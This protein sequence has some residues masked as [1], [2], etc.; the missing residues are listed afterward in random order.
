MYQI[1]GDQHTLENA[2]YE[3]HVMLFSNGE[4]GFQCG[5]FSFCNIQNLE[6]MDLDQNLF[7]LAKLKVDRNL[8]GTFT[9]PED[10]E[11]RANEGIIN[12][13]HIDP[14]NH[15]YTLSLNHKM[16]DGNT[17]TGDYEGE[18]DYKWER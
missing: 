8:N 10:N 1:T 16:D 5:E 4:N 11:I 15:I 6:N 18:F 3:M 2:N 13:V 17:L 9:D 7:M 14:A 12:V